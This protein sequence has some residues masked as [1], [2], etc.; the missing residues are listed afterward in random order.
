MHLAILSIPAERHHHLNLIGPET[1]KANQRSCVTESRDPL[2]AGHR[3][4]DSRC[5][6]HGRGRKAAAQPPSRS[7]R[8]GRFHKAT[9]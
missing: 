7:T 1:T 8:N 9:T 3:L 4:G 2:V 5:N 6:K